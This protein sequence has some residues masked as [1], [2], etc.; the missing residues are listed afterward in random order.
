MSRTLHLGKQPAQ[1]DGRDLMLADYLDTAKLPKPP[2]TFGHED[3]M[4]LPRL[5]LGNGPDDT[6]RK[7]FKGAGD[8]VF[9]MICNAVRLACTIGGHAVHFTGKEAIAAYSEVTGYRIG[10]DSTDQGT[11]M[12]VALNWWRNTGIK[13]ASGKRH[14]LGA[15]AVI[16]MSAHNLTEIF[17]ALYVLDV[18]VALGIDF[19][20]SADTQFS[21]GKPWSVVKGSPSAGGHAIL[22]DAKRLPDPKVETWAHDQ[23]ATQGFLKAR[24]DEA[25]ALFMPEMLVKGK[26]LE[27]FDTTALLADLKAVTR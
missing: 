4:P 20:E 13:D 25:Y 11:D 6:V 1:P 2:T 7:D 8:C 17:E 5:M 14:K 10:D 27:G 12:H 9:A 26:S 23:P 18:G 19:P 22:L 24:V 15:Y 16:D 21:E 3:R